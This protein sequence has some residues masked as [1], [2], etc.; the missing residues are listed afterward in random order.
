MRGETRSTRREKA[1]RM[2]DL[3]GDGVPRDAA[4][5]TRRTRGGRMK[6][7]VEVF[8]LDR[9]LHLL[10]FPRL[11]AFAQT[12]QGTRRLSRTGIAVSTAVAARSNERRSP[13]PSSERPSHS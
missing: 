1:P 7:A 12:R 4:D 3:R 2:I 13:C 9:L 10:G 5:I 8:R 6:K 11:D